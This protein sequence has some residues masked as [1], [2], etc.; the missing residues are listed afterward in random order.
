MLIK[1]IS[2]AVLCRDCSGGAQGTLA[3]HLGRDLPL[4]AASGRHVD[5]EIIIRD[6]ESF[7]SRNLF[8]SRELMTENT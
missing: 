5:A 2:S 7:S 3:A 6:V 4:C 8:H 1:G